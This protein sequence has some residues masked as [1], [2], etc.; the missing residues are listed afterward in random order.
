MA[1]EKYGE[2]NG[3][4]RRARGNERAMVSSKPRR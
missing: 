3:A 1:P 2:E 4:A